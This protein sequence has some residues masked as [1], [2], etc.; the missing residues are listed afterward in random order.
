MHPRMSEEIANSIT[1]GLGAL[2]SIAGL[3][4]LVVFAALHGNAWKVVSC[5]VYGATLVILYTASTLY[6][7]FYGPKI[8]RFFNILDHAAIYVLIAGSYTPFALVNL[9]GNGGWIHRRPLG[10]PS[11]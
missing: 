5:A 8:K 6:H 7:S 1:H 3:V 11:R 4:V 10:G 2:L 9:R